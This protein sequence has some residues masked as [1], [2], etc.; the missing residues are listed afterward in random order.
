MNK[1]TCR[2]SRLGIAS[3]RSDLEHFYVQLPIEDI[4][5]VRL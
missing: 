1:K 4:Y 3:M 5:V 2:C